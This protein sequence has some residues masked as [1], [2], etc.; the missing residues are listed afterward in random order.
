MDISAWLFCIF[1][2]DSIYAI[3][4]IYA[5][6]RP[7]VYPSVTCESNSCIM[8]KQLKLGLRNFHHTV[9]LP[10]SFLRASIVPK[11]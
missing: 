4:R 11:F 5:I 1:M 8:Q 3:V 2:R 9:A 10:L 6:S 7:S